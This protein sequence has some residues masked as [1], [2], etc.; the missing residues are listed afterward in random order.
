MA[1]AV[2]LAKLPDRGL[3]NLRLPTGAPATPSLAQAAGLALPETPCSYTAGTN[4]A[5]YWLA[6]GEWLVA[7]T[8]GVENELEDRL[9]DALDGAGAVVDVSAG[10]LRYN[11]RGPAAALLLMKAS[12]YDFDRRTFGPGR[13]VQTVFAKTT[14]LVARGE[15]ESFD[16]AIR[17]SYTDY[18]ERWTTDAVSGYSG[19]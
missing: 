4:A 10:Y 3:L 13:C 16:L 8:A 7:V 14:A 1:D 6:P 11:L 5:A 9:R 18:F 17:R 2:V 12:P 15:D 19:P